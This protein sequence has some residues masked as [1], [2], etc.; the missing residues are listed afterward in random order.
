MAVC[1]QGG[2]IMFNSNF[3]VSVMTKDGRVVKDSPNGIAEI[4]VGT[5]FCVRIRNKHRLNCAVDVLVDGLSVTKAGRIVVL[6]NDYAD[7]MGFIGAD[8]FKAEKGKQIIEA[9]FY[10]QEEEIEDRYGISKRPLYVQE[11]EGEMLATSWY[12]DEWYR[13]V[14]SGKGVLGVNETKVFTTVGEVPTLSLI[15]ETM[16]MSGVI[17]SGSIS[18]SNDAFTFNRGIHDVKF[19]KE[20]TVLKITVKGITTNRR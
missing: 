11:K 6:G 7:I 19:E 10:L 4:P 20:P 8:R 18:S 13:A 2:L 5:E 17:Q 14:Q 1:A 12:P 15:D 9:L 16:D 3:V